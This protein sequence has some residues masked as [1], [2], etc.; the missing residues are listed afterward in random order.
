MKYMYSE[1]TIVALSSPLGKGAIAII[2]LSG[3]ACLSIT[4]RLFSTKIDASHVRR[5]VTGAIYASSDRH[6]IDQVV[7]T[8]FKSPHSYTGEDVVEISCHCNPII[9]D[10]LLHEATS[11]GARIAGPGEFTER[12]FLNHKMDLSQAEAVAGIIEAKSRQTLSQSL[13]QLEGKLSEKIHHIKQAI[14]NIASL[15]EVNLDFNEDDVQV[16][17]TTE[18]VTRAKVLVENIDQLIR[19]YHYGR[20]LNEGLKMVLLGKP[21]VGKSSLLN[22]F[23]EKQRAI[24]SEIPGTTR[25]YIDGFTEMEGI[26]IQV[27]DTAGVRETLDPIEDIGVQ[28]ALEHIETADIVLALFEANGQIT[29]DDG[30]LVDYIAEAKN[31]VPVILVANK[32]DLGINST[33][34]ETLKELNLP[35]VQIS[36][37]NETNIEELK[38][39]IKEHLL[40]DSG[41]EEDDI[42]VTNRRHKAALQRTRESVDTFIRGLQSGL[43]EV[44]LA[45][46][47]RSALDHIGEIIG[48]TT[49]EDLLNNIFGQF[50]IGK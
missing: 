40:S 37:L 19:S 25:D 38:R 1:D 11:L 36:A 17:E 5:A 41:V 49:T 10:R 21:N 33:V 22:I 9:I 34:L 48:E 28:K 3:D 43:D 24:V 6:L 42:I 15:I 7:V 4:N 29:V 45:G 27:I 39:N 16:Y 2:R 50:C 44:V 8:Y 12:A 30:R 20:L 26:P 32:T 23:L 13:R 35:V 14:V 31:R 46:E 47:L 18:V